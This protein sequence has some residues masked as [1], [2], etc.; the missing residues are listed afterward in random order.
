[1]SCF[2]EVFNIMIVW[3]KPIDET[4]FLSLLLLYAYTFFSIN[5]LPSH[6]FN[7]VQK[8]SNNIKYSRFIRIQLNRISLNRVIAVN[9]LSSPNL[10]LYVNP[11]FSNE[12]I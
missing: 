4:E 2:A 1:M 10:R 6:Q 8:S 3:K 11:A 9:A 5:K 12:Y 7:F